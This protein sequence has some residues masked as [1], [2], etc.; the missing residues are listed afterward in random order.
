MALAAESEQA[1]RARR[2]FIT[3][4]AG[5]L[6]KRLIVLAM[7]LPAIALAKSPFDGTWMTKVDSIKISGKPD[8]YELNNGMYDCS[9]CVPAY[10]IKADGSEQPVAGHDYVDH[11][12]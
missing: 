9:S 7:L 3:N 10:K 11:E 6:M 8:V 2:K 1:G 12:S 5:D 4:N